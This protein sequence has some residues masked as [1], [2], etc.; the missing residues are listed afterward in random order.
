MKI[1]IIGINIYVRAMNYACPLHAYAFQQY[2]KEQGIESEIIDYLPN[3]NKFEKGYDYKHPS[4]YFGK[5][6]ELLRK[7]LGEVNEDEEAN[8]EICKIREKINKYEHQK[9]LYEAIYGQRETRFLKQQEFIKSYLTLSDD[10]YNCAIMETMQLDYDGYICVTDIIWDKF[11]GSG[12][13][14]GF[15][16]GLSCMENKWK[17][18]YSASKLT[19]DSNEDKIITSQWINDMDFVSVRESFLQKRVMDEIRADVTWVLD[20]VLLNDASCYDRILKKPE[21]VNYLLLYYVV[22]NNPEI[23]N[24]AIQFAQAHNLKIIELTDKLEQNPLTKACDVDVEYKYDVGI[25]EWLGYI[26]YATSIFTNSFHGC[27][28]SIIFEKDFYVSRRQNYD[29]I[30]D[31]LVSLNLENRIIDDFDFEKIPITINNWELVKDRLRR[32]RRVSENYLMNALDVVQQQPHPI[33]DYSKL[34]RKQEYTMLY[35]IGK[36]LKVFDLY[37]LSEYKEQKNK[38]IQ[39]KNSIEYRQGR[40]I[41]DGSSMFH[42]NVF[43]IEGCSFVGYRIRV[44]FDYQN[45][46]L[47]KDGS[48]QNVEEYR[49]NPR[50][51][52]SIFFPGESIPYIPINRIKAVVAECLW[53]ES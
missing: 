34:K 26:K 3:T 19:A 51:I 25:E 38:F 47:L 18:A 36:P 1:C 49:K 32:R 43:V 37:V 4:I 2:L 9:A 7:Q 31:L 40:I 46:Y 23:I 24:K 13:E 41:N 16:L 44:N 22:E 50:C 48:F 52:H 29:K 5:K 15:F 8:P 33:K 12:Y 17:I 20:P 11:P 39:R 27:C 53:E 10:K 35:N 6:I 42:E 28:L 30:S 45:Y 21:E 14:P